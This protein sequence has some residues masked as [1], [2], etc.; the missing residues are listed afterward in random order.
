V[1]GRAER[2]AREARYVALCVGWASRAG[3]FVAASFSVWFVVQFLF[4][5]LHRIRYPFELEWMEG[6]VAQHVERVLAGK[7]LYV[8]PSLEF[9]PYIYNP[10]YYYVSAAASR[11]LGQ[12]LF[13]LRAVS[14][15]STLVLFGLLY[16]LIARDT[17]SRFAGL[18]AVGLFAAT[19]PLSGNWLDLARPDALFLVLLL[20]SVY[21]VRF[22]EKPRTLVIG[23]VLF[24]LSYFTKQSAGPMLPSLVLYAFV[25]R[26]FRGSSWFIGPAIGLL[27]AVMLVANLV[28][29]GWYLFYTFSLPM[30]HGVNDL[31]A[32]FWQVEM[33]QRVPV[34]IVAYAVLLAGVRDESNRRTWLFYA[35]LTTSLLL[36]GYLSRIHNGSFLNDLLPAHLGL[37]IAA[38]V[39]IGTQSKPSEGDTANPRLAWSLV[40]IVQLSFLVYDSAPLVPRVEDRVAGFALLEKLRALP[41]DVLLTHRPYLGELAGKA[42]YAPFM[43][44]S[45]VFKGKDDPRGAKRMAE[46]AFVTALE[47]HRFSKVIVDAEDWP[48]MYSL[49]QH[50]H[51]VG[52]LLY[53]RRDTFWPI[54][55]GRI[56]PEIVYAPSAH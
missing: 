22:A 45:D 30:T 23:A 54:T 33:M 14:F 50:Y 48:F 12:G 25:S 35:P 29:H 38:G 40:A 9:V 56:R 1:T 3:M 15:A 19:Y 2:G 24:C 31:V 34:L 46:H 16:S 5:A 53:A 11:V 13:A 43:A 4:V 51:R 41:G 47:Q 10:F 44:Y 26:G 7:P 32:E 17:R 39:V 55:G 20:G 49:K 27:A 21:C 8:A 36:A 18:V 42:S 52:G 6:G 28:T 37:S